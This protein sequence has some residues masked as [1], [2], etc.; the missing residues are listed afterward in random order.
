MTKSSFDT[1][2][3]PSKSNL[4]QQNNIVTLQYTEKEI[5]T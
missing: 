3:I 5:V 1:W 2:V 4:V